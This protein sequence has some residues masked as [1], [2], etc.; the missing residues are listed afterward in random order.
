MQC[1]SEIQGHSRANQQNIK[2]KKKKI[3]MST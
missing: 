2:L 1:F 3:R